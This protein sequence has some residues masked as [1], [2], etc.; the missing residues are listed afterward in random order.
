MRELWDMVGLHQTRTVHLFPKRLFAT[1]F[2]WTSSMSYDYFV[3]RIKLVALRIGLPVDDYSGH[4]LCVGE[5]S[6]L[7]VARVPYFVIKK[8]G[9]WSS[10]AAMVYYPHDE[11][12]VRK[13]SAASQ[14]VAT[15]THACRGTTRPA[16]W[17]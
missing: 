11:D 14:L 17:G 4:S 1:R 7:F 12:V 15:S 6:D 10:D 16:Y 13:V 5:A 8:T 9:R 2:D 3:S